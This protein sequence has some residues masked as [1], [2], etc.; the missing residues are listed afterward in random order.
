MTAQRFKTQRDAARARSRS[1][2]RRAARAVPALAFA[3][4]GPACVFST[5]PPT[6]TCEGIRSLR[7][8][9]TPDEVKSA[10]GRPEESA[11][12]HYGGHLEE[13][14]SYETYS[15]FRGLGLTVTFRD[16]SLVHVES[17]YKTIVDEP[18]EFLYRLTEK[19]RIEYDGFRDRFSCRD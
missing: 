5:L 12:D 11:R 4:F 17:R 19:E 14:W 3:L 9:M 7:I 8:G 13:W 10:I 1:S 2:L 16:S 6:V 15:L 18:G